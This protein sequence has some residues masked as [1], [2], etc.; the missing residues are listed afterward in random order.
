VLIFVLWY[1]YKRGREERLEK[2]RL[3]AAEGQSDLSSVSE[4]E[5]DA[6]TD[7]EDPSK[8]EGASTHPPS[9]QDPLPTSS[10]KESRKGN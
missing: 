1:C 3:S 2:E 7:D 5:G 6:I 8:L 9:A 4:F 10:D